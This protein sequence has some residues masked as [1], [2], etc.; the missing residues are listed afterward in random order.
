M[1]DPRYAIY[2]VPAPETA[3]YQAGAALLGYDV[4]SGKPLPFPEGLALGRDDWS[5]LTAEPRAYGFHATLKAPFRLAPGQRADDLAMRLETFA[6]AARARVTIMPVV[7][8]IGRFAALLPG[9]P[10]PALDAL[11][12]DC[13]RSF[14][15]FRAPLGDGERHRRLAA[16]LT[17]RHKD[18]LERWGYPYVFEDFRFHLTLTGP[19][20][21]AAQAAVLAC[22]RGKLGAIEGRPLPVDRVALLCQPDGDTPFR[23][24]AS[25][26]LPAH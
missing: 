14:D 22:L 19:I 3:L 1:P 11:A 6:R 20:A 9:E 26:L 21:P 18:N 13:V 12:A 24:I 16:P 5:A 4:Y 17:V 25:A 2:F 23:L 8:T 7:R 10:C 15:S